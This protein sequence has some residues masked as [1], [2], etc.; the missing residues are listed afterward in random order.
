M[1][2][3]DQIKV[4]EIEDKQIVSILFATKSKLFELAR[5]IRSIKNNKLEDPNFWNSLV[6]VISGIA[7]SDLNE[8]MRLTIKDWKDIKPSEIKTEIMLAKMPYFHIS[9][10]R[11]LDTPAVYNP[12]YLGSGGRTTEKIDLCILYVNRRVNLDIDKQISSLYRVFI[13][14]YFHAIQNRFLKENFGIQVYGSPKIFVEGSAMFVQIYVGS[15]LD[16]KDTTFDRVKHNFSADIKRMLNQDGIES[17]TNPYRIYDLGFLGL[18]LLYENY[19]NESFSRTLN[20]IGNNKQVLEAF[21][22]ETWI[23]NLEEA[24]KKK[25]NNLIKE[26]ERGN[27]NTDYKAAVRKTIRGLKMEEKRICS[28][29]ND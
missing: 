11:I 22:S 4:E 15:C 6:E 16:Q 3:E 18:G 29:S 7:L 25:E 20:E 17:P 24:K 2:K 27:P 26:V 9:R 23:K 8:I 28:M 10:K 12:Q 1:A 21:K 19:E 13:H 14:E 5:T